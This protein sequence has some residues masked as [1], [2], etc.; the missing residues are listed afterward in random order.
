MRLSWLRTLVLSMII[1]LCLGAA[2][3]GGYA[4]GG[5]RGQNV[6]AQS[7]GFDLLYQVQDLLDREFIGKVPAQQAQVYGAI[8]GLVSSY[9]D[10]YTVFV[11]PASREVERDELRG[12]F[13][14]IG[15]YL[16]RDKAGDMVVAVMRDRP[17]AKA[18]IQDGDIL[19][20]V[21]DTP[22]TAEMTS[23][24]V[25]ALIRGEVGTQVKLT[26]RRP[27]QTEPFTVE[28]VREQIVTPSVE[29]RLPDE[30]GHIGYIRISRFAENT[31]EELKAG[32]AELQSKGVQKLVLD[33]RG[34][35][36]GLVDSAVDTTSLFLREGQVLHEV[37]RGGQER[38]Y[39]VKRVQSPAQDWGLVLLVDGGTASASEI[40]AGALRDQARAILIGENTYGKGSVQ[41]VHELSD[42]SSLHVTV[43]RWLTPNRQQIDSTGLAPDVPIQISA[44]DQAAGRD[45]QLD[46]A[47][48]WL[49]EEK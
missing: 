42:G 29:W 49:R 46:R 10:P 33:L 5:R 27:G 36:G 25:I 41:Q 48:S 18:G 26:L 20:A 24:E 1:T 40:L 21:D 6:K 44:D 23:E 35:G 22:I 9:N 13:G 31:A 17:A 32:I 15:A 14:G 30:A 11:E 8:H 7:F 2:F 45:P 47:L 12:H 43:A 16:D 19:L 4:L 37:K 38:F 28:I 34:N 39:P 3:L